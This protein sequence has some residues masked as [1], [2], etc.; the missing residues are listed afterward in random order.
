MIMTEIDPQAAWDAFLPRLS[1]FY[2]GMAFTAPITFPY[3]R[4]VA[5]IHP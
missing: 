4:Q 3:E 1:D 2:R 5:A